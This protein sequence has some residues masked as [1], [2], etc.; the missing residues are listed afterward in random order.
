M[1]KHLTIFLF[2]IYSGF[3]FEICCVCVREREGEGEGIWTTTFFVSIQVHRYSYTMIF[4][5]EFHLS[6]SLDDML[7]PFVRGFSRYALLVAAG[8]GSNGKKLLTWEGNLF[9][10]SLLTTS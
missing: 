3:F 6:H 4:F 7:S 1:K 5:L 9:T 10:E 8:S 2:H